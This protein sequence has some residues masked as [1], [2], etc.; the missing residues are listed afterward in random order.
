MREER[1]DI[2][3]WVGRARAICVT[4]NGDV[5]Q[6]GEA[7]MGRG[8][9]LQ[10]AQRWPG[11]EMVL[12]SSIR[13]YGNIVRVLGFVGEERTWIISFPV[14]HHWRSK[15]D[16]GLILSSA[17]QL[18]TVAEMSELTGSDRLIALPRPGCG[19]GGLSWTD[20]KPLIAPL[21][22]DRFVIVERDAK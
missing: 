13:R 21:L 2:F 6:R 3:S 9:A 1:G 14:K 12:G 5:N 11:I 15:A 19:S 7:V 16:M 18:R 20:V 8:V 17:R 22:G 10:A 4:T